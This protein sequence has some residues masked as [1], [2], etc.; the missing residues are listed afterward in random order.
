[1]LIRKTS[2]VS[3]KVHILDLP[4]TNAQ[5]AAYNAGALVQDAFPDLDADGREFLISGITP[6]EWAETFPPDEEN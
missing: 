1:M 6:E 4:V 3:G 5:F 2:I